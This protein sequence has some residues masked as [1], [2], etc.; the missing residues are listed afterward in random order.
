MDEQQADADP[1]A[2]IAEMAE[3]FGIRV[4]VAESLTGGLISSRLA[5]AGGASRWYAGAIVAYGTDVKQAVL[6]VPAGPVVSEPAA[7]AMALGV[8]RL[9]R[10]D[11]ALSITGVGG[12][13]RQ[14]DEPPGTIWVC[15]VT[16]AR[17][18]VRRWEIPGNGPADICHRATERALR[19]LQDELATA[20]GDGS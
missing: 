1:A 12:P 19:Y 5:E 17:R 7:T 14:D 9:L 8:S 16:P 4:A 11:A 15:V 13:D 2:A 3:Q 10:A 20:I 18:D 6:G